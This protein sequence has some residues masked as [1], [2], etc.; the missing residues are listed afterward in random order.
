MSLDAIQ[1]ILSSAVVLGSLYAI[2]AAGLALTWTTL[3]IFNFAHGALMMIGAYFAWQIGADAGFGLGVAA[4]MA[5]GVAALVGL[6]VVFER[7]VIRPFLGSRQ[8]VLITVITTLAAMIF[9][10]NS[11]LLTWGPRMKQMPPVLPQGISVMG[12]SFSAAELLI[13]IAAPVTLIALWL[14]LT[15]TRLGTAVRAVAQNP[16][17]AALMGLNVSRLYSL[18]FAVSAGLAGFSGILLGSM[19]FITP[20]MGVEPL[21][22]ALV[23]VIFGGL[24]SLGGTIG[25]AYIIG[26]LEATSIYF[27][28]LYWTPAL[29]FLV[30]IVVLVIRPQGLFGKE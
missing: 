7:L 20:T 19:R 25:A 18:A 16:E 1:S 13:V 30:I 5:I 28:G 24:G 12:I 21:I 3:G 10:Q 14:F 17:A 2:M 22:K 23:V 6:G 4:G 9:I 29:L 27:I 11:A 8:V 15:R 26:F